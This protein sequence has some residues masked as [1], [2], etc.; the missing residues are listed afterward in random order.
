MDGLEQ[1]LEEVI[2]TLQTDLA[3]FRTGRATPSM[4][5]DL[6]VEVY[7]SRM[8]LK[9]LAAITAPEPRQILV[10]PW[11]KAVIVEIEKALRAKGFSPVVEGDFL[12]VVLPSLTGEER[13]KVM[14]EVGERA[15]EAKI[16]LRLVRREAVEK[17]EAA[18][19]SK[20]ISEDDEF[21]QKKKIDELTEEFN[22]K[23][24]QVSQEKQ[25]QIEL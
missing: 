10:S 21:V 16:A 7:D 2:R 15:E 9:E 18:E 17:V 11:D 5:E 22:K 23:I 8:L 3:T 6:E 19:K 4:I 25:T 13:E 12:R 20:E 14:R 24:D 1:K